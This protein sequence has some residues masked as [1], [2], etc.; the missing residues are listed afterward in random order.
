MRFNSNE[1]FY[2]RTRK[3]W[4]F[5]TGD[6][7]IEVIT[8]AGLRGGMRRKEVMGLSDIIIFFNLSWFPALPQSPFSSPKKCSESLRCN[9]KKISI[10]IQN[11]KLWL[12]YHH[13]SDVDFHIVYVT[14]CY[15]YMDQQIFTFRL[16]SLFCRKV[17]DNWAICFLLN[18]FIY[19][20]LQI[21][22]GLNQKSGKVLLQ[23]T[24]T[25]EVQCRIVHRNHVIWRTKIIKFWRNGNDSKQPYC[26]RKRL[27]PPF[28]FPSRWL[29]VSF[30]LNYFICIKDFN[31]ETNT[32][33]KL[34][35]FSFFMAVGII[36]GKRSAFLY[37]FGR[38]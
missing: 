23:C 29:K 36:K 27:P 28:F 11:R 19:I 25:P 17:Y 33:L 32:S 2:D 38:K 15:I 4:P 21:C 31:A 10:T 3:R 13:T 30:Q 22:K 7:L 5:N 20:R 37:I 26:F 8:W 35:L 14:Y 9:V 24:L 16:V 12:V 1:I 6:F 34:N 18:I